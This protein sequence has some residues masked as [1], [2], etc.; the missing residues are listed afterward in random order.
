VTQIL[1]LRVKAMRALGGDALGVE[2]QADEQALLPAFNAGAHIELQLGNGLRRCY[3]LLNAQDE[4]RRYVVGVSRAPASRGG[5]RF[6]HEELR[7]G[8]RVLASAPR[9]N[10]PLTEDALATVLIAGGVGVTPIWCMVQRLEALQRPWRLYYAARTR[11]QAPLLD[12]LEKLAKSSACGALTVNFDHE[13][14]GRPWRIDE[15]IAQQNRAAHLY[16]CGPAPMLA[17]FE[18]ATRDWPAKQVHLERFT[19]AGLADKSAAFSVR[20][21]RSGRTVNVAEGQSILDAVLAAGVDA[22]YS[23][24]EGVC[25]TCET[26]VLAGAPEH[27]CA[28]LS[29]AERA[30]GR[31]MM[32]CCSRSRG[33]ALEL[34]L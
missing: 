14:D 31:S 26:R 24:L 15:L 17:A 16:C 32:I 8:H 27:H 34:D 20:L 2:L 6:I 18:T 9:N 33:G 11:A 25:G 23:C 30:E 4:R 21:V 10:F 5:S 19:A 22:P 13:A 3:S 1:E 28:V 7:V 12:R 29:A